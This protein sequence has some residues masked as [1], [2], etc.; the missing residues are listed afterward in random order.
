MQKYQFLAGGALALII[1]GA[2][3]SA[4]ILGQKNS[5]ERSL[6][7]KSSKSDFEELVAP[8]KGTI[9]PVVWGNL[10]KRMVDTGVIDKEKFEAIYTQ[11]GGLSDADKALLYGENNG[12]LVI[13]RENAG[14]ILNLLWGFGLGNKNEVLEKGPMVDPQYGG[15]GR[16]ASTGGWTIARGNPMNHYS[17]HQFIKLTAEQQKSVEN[18][19]KN[20]YRPCCGN[21]TY[22][23][24]CNHGMAMLGLL[25]LMASQNASEAD[26]YK[27][28]LAV[29]S[30]W[31][32]D[33]YMT[34]AKYFKG[35][36]VEW[37]AVDSKQALGND[38]SS[39]SGIQRVTSE[40]SPEESSGG[41]SCGV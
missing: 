38:F 16:F 34:I 5:E 15:A 24:D 8:E 33:T 29:N 35:K 3:A 31:F 7:P 18:V 6:V 27:T 14:F 12:K 20:I 13:N 25:E 9:L 17:H 30:Y 2:I 21:S 10:G 36:G 37:S 23:P 40:V 1:F 28:A 22:F 19:S 4:S 41:G 39:A 32:P 11:R 26:M